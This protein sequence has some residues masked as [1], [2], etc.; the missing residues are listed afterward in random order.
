MAD[1]E[2]PPELGP[3]QLF[4][5]KVASVTGAAVIVL[6]VASTLAEDF[7]ANQAEQMA[8]LKGG[9]AFW[10][11]MERKLYKLAD[12]PD[13]PPEKK[14]KIVDAL[15]KLAVKYRPYADAIVR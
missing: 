13:L 12:G 5:V 8:I 11:L 4:L 7:V 1:S 3:L 10:S 9:P 6:Y 2:I 14:Q 15:R